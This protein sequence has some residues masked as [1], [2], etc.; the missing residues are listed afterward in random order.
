MSDSFNN[1]TTVQRQIRETNAQQHELTK[2][3]KE[4]EEV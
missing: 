3:L 4:K 2:K 1:S